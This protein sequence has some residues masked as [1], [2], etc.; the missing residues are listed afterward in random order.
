MPETAAV[1]DSN[2]AVEETGTEV[3]EEGNYE[4][5]PGRES[6]AVVSPVQ[7]DMKADKEV[8]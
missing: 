2:T 4:T 3:L 6:V 1:W 7:E 5:A 8:P